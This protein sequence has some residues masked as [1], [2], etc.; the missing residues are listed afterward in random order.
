MI[1]DMVLCIDSFSLNTNIGNNHIPR[2]K[3]HCCKVQVCIVRHFFS[4]EW[5]IKLNSTDVEKQLF[6]LLP[7]RVQSQLPS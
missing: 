5:T 2:M 7:S 1:D 4:L 3:L 6:T